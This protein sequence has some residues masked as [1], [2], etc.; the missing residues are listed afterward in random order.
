MFPAA[1]VLRSWRHAI[2]GLLV[3]V[4]VSFSGPVRSQAENRDRLDLQTVCDG[5]T[6]EMAACT[7]ALADK[8]DRWLENVSLSFLRWRIA[9]GRQ[10]GE[11]GMC[12]RDYNPVAA[13]RATYDDFILYRA[14]MMRLTHD[15]W[16]P[17][18]IVRVAVPGVALDLTVEHT[19][20]LLSLCG[21]DAAHL[22]QIDLTK[23]DWCR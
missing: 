2:A 7:G 17:G 8:A 12:D 11:A 15:T 13:H 19:R 23:E 6:Y 1:V 16:A 22:E 18:S 20:R 9:T 4:A 21:S 14:N 10:S 5:S 3:T